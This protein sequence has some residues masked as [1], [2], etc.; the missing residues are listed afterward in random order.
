M[1]SNKEVILL[2]AGEPASIS[3]E[4]TIKALESQKINKNIKLVSITDPAMVEENKKIINSNIK[5]NE[6][7]DINKDLNMANQI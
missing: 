5:I 7:R 1:S 3:T 6:I 4:I 2:T